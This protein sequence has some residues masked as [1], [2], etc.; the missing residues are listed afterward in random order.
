L[1]ERLDGTD[2][3][4]DLKGWRPNRVLAER[5]RTPLVLVHGGTGNLITIDIR[6]LPKAMDTDNSILS[7][8]RIGVEERPK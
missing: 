2:F 4:G 3:D 7:L 6:Q 8:R 5:K 1:W